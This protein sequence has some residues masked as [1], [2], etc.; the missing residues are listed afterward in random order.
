M[1]LIFKTK[2]KLS[3]SCHALRDTHSELL[4]LPNPTALKALVI[5]TTSK[6]QKLISNIVVSALPKFQ[7]LNGPW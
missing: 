6:S 1:R 3:Q 5:T 4:K 2:Q 7:L